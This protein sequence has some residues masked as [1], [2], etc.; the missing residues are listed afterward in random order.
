VTNI[1]FTHL[2]SNVGE[3][4]HTFLTQVESF[5]CGPKKIEILRGKLDEWLMKVGGGTVEAAVAAP[6]D[7]AAAASGGGGTLSAATE[8]A[9]AAA[10]DGAV[11][12]TTAAAAAVGGDP[13]AAA[14]VAAASTSE[15]LPPLNGDFLQQAAPALFGHVSEEQAKALVA[16]AVVTTWAQGDVIT[17]QVNARVCVCGV[18]M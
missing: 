5:P 17:E 4:G 11:S 7:A 8:V 15:Q 18:Q 14:A 3:C 1:A 12:P 10:G 16:G 9:G 6:S 13:T 2:F